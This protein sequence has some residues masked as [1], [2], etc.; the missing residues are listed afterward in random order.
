MGVFPT[1][2]KAERCP[3]FICVWQA[4]MY[5][6][7]LDVTFSKIN[8]LAGSDSVSVAAARQLNQECRQLLMYITQFMNPRIRTDSR[9]AEPELIHTHRQFNT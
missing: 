3:I 6:T 7:R 1:L 2:T 4:C 5:P 8:N 9:T